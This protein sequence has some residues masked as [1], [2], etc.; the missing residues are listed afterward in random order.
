MS[1]ITL[2]SASCDASL[3]PLSSN[4]RHL[5]VYFILSLIFW[6]LRVQC[7]RV[8]R[9][10]VRVGGLGALGLA[11]RS[12]CMATSLRGGRRKW[13]HGNMAAS[14]ILKC[15]PTNRLQ[16]PGAW[17]S[18]WRRPG[19]QV[20]AS[21]RRWNPWRVWRQWCRIGASVWWWWTIVGSWTGW[22]CRTRRLWW[23]VT[24]GRWWYRIC[25]NGSLSI[26]AL[27]N[28]GLGNLNSILTWAAAARR[29][30]RWPRMPVLSPSGSSSESDP[31]PGKP[32]RFVLHFNAGRELKRER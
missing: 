26:K 11:I 16:W 8:V 29:A 24:I 32:L 21:V 6:S 28:H 19:I 1:S 18:K 31:V 9:V 3:S 27:T 20:G 25:F 10:R 4:S 2:T 14:V 12:R 30:A 23:R 17:H 7:F 15:W 5:R 13:T 22:W